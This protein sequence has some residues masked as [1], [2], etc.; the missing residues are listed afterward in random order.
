MPHKVF[1]SEEI[2]NVYMAL[3]VVMGTEEDSKA[4][5]LEKLRYHK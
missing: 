5:N 2:K 4:I 1:E 3:G